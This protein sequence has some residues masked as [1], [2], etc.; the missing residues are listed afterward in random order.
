MNYNIRSHGKEPEPYTYL[1][2]EKEDYWFLQ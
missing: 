2:G 1:K